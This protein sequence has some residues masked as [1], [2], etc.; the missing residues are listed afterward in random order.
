MKFL[1]PTKIKVCSDTK[2]ISCVR[3]SFFSVKTYELWYDC[4]WPGGYDLLGR[5]KDQIRTVEQ[6]NAT[7]TACKDLKLD[8][9]VI[10]GGK[11]DTL[12]FW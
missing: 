8:G 11:V 12:I 1:Q 7:L 2:I 5:T 6:V 10:I 4:A 3:V 9:L